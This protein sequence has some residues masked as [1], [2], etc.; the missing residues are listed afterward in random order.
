MPV[1]HHSFNVLTINTKNVK[2]NSAQMLQKNNLSQI[3]QPSSRQQRISG[4]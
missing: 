3:A 4:C 2:K 1:D